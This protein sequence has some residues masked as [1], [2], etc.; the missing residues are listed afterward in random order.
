MLVI[1][2]NISSNLF[3]QSLVVI[4]TAYLIYRKSA[5]SKDE[6][7][8]VE[9]LVERVYQQATGR[10]PPEDRPRPGLGGYWHDHSLGLIFVAAC[11]FFLLLQTVTGWVS[12]TASQASTHQSSSF[13]VF[14]ISTW[15]YNTFQNWQ[16]D[17]LGP[18]VQLVLA[19]HFIY[20]GSSQSKE[21]EER[22][23]TLLREVAEKLPQTS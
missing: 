8:D 16:A 5:E 20:R 17:L 19:R 2:S 14:L 3:G 18:A 13:G 23:K 22:M 6:E 7:D 4:L 11:I 10:E 21:G 12:Y 9:E 1:F 15:G